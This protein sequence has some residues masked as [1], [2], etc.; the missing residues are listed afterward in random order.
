MG[1]ITAEE[2]H[3][4]LKAVK[5]ASNDAIMRFIAVILIASKSNDINAS[6]QVLK[7]LEVSPKEKLDK[8]RKIK[9]N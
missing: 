4:L 7:T 1:D 8:L 3:N 9:K 6:I 5:E 2:A